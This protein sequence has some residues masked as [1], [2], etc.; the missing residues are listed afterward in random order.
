ML[1]YMK[2]LQVGPLKAGIPQCSILGPLLFSVYVNDRVENIHSSIRLLADDTGLYII[3]DDPINAAYQL[4]NGLQKIH[5]RAKMW[6]VSFNPAKSESMIF[7]RK[8]NKPYHPPIFMNQTRIE[9]GP[10]HKHLGAVYSNDCTLNEHPD[11]KKS[12]EWTHINIMR[13]LK[14]KLDRRCRQ[15]TCFS[16]IRPVIEFSDVVW[17]N[18]A[19]Y[20]ANELRKI[21]IEAARIVAGATK[22]VSIDSLYTGTGWEL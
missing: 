22:L 18:C 14:F 1:Y 3:V 10:S 20:E 7:S 5:L 17:D 2:Q 16:F 9:E 6:L 12:K 4:N 8:R 19:L 13:K 21:Q 11:Y 15:S